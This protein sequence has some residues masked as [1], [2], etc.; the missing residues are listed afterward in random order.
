MVDHPVQPRKPPAPVRLTLT[1]RTEELVQL[2]WMSGF[3]AGLSLQEQQL[4]CLFC[5]R[6]LP[7]PVLVPHIS[8]L[9]EEKYTGTAHSVATAAHDVASSS[10]ATSA[11]ANVSASVS[12]DVL[13]R[14]HTTAAASAHVNEQ[15]NGLHKHQSSQRNINGASHTIKTTGPPLVHPAFHSLR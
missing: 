15:G 4:S 11:S 6:N 8:M 14:N 1:S 12:A 3:S 9:K 2:P 13:P 5:S 7:L 10:L